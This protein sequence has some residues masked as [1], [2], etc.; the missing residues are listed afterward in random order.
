MRFSREYD[1]PLSTPRA[2]IPVHSP[3]PPALPPLSFPLFS[4]VFRERNNTLQ[5]FF[6]ELENT[7][8]LQFRYLNFNLGQY[9]AVVGGNLFL[10]G[11]ELRKNGTHK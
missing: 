1:L 9:L 2:N 8:R 7:V 6:D 11:C 5:S 4:V 3:R 10:Q